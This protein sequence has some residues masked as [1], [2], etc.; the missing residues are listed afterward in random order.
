MGGG[1]MLLCDEHKFAL[2][3]YMWDTHRTV[4]EELER[5]KIKY[6]IAFNKASKGQESVLNVLELFDNTLEIEEKIRGF[7]KDWV[8]SYIPF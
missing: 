3:R 4:L 6:D 1:T 8:D 7:I 5:A 2:D